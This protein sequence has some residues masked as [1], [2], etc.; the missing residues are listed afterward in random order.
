M[1]TVQLPL[2]ADR[3]TMSDLDFCLSD[4]N[5]LFS[6]LQTLHFGVLKLLRVVATL[7]RNIRP[8]SSLSL[9]DAT[10]I[11]L[12]ISIFGKGAGGAGMENPNF[13]IS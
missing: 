13:F 4:L 2:S 8:S 10:S 9:D 6:S 7:A 1:I 3:M 12:I 5:T 11:A